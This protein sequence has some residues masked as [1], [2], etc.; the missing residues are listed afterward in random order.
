MSPGIGESGAGHVAASTGAELPPFLLSNA[1]YYGTLAAVRSL[2]R[3]GV[4]VVTVDPSMLAAGRFSR[5]ASQHL[6]CPPFDHTEAWIG[7]LMRLGREGP[8]RAIYATSDAVSFALA[9]HR[10]ALSSS[11]F[12]LQPPLETMMA[13]L[14]KGRLLD[15]ARAVGLDVPDTWLPATRREVAA[16]ASEAGGALLIKPRSQLSVRSAIKGGLAPAGVDSVLAQYDLIRKDTAFGSEMARRYP[17]TL[18]PMLQRYHPQ[19]MEAVYSL[20]GFRD[21]SGRHFVLLGSRKILQRPR[22]LGIGLCFEA[23]PVDEVL[24]KQIERLCARIGYYGAFEIEF[25]RSEGRKLLIDFNARFY[26]QMVFDMVRGLNLPGLV[27][28]SAIGN[29]AEVERLLSSIPPAGADSGFAFCNQLGLRIA[30]GAQR[31]FGTMTREEAARW[32][33]WRRERGDRIVDAIKDADDPLPTLV[34]LTRN[35]LQCV[36]HPRSFIRQIAMAG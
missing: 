9:C 17:E 22:R 30:I 3:A 18:E 32:R 31:A 19:A 21:V 14:D 10:E 1:D 34:D 6:S 26:N 20:S 28:A 8:R 7:W 25:I 11:F 4:P 5:Y 15:H 12:L 24:A 36:R 27:Y 33:N 23:E 16:V 29:D 2:G 13:V 35:V